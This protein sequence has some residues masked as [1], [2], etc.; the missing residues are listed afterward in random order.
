MTI[1][2][3]SHA[4]FWWTTEHERLS[5]R[6]Y[7]AIEGQARVYVSAVVAWEVSNKV[8]LG[9][10]PGAKTLSER[11]VETVEHYGW[12]PLPISI[13]H[14]RLAGTFPAVH[15][16]PFDR[17]LA[18]QARIEDLMLVTADPAFRDFPVTT[19]W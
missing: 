14:A 3:D 4:F 7:A 2:L 18:A 6:A 12:L 10:W 16:D 17:M 9:K 13:E 19:L 1:L 15:R 8:R 11:F 5:T